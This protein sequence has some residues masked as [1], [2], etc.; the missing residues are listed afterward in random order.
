M[1]TLVS[2]RQDL[3]LIWT[4]TYL[5]H[6]SNNI[7][8]NDDT[9]RGVDFPLIALPMVT[10]RRSSLADSSFVRS[11][12]DDTDDGVDVVGVGGFA[13]FV[14]L[15]SFEGVDGDDGVDDV[16]GGGFEGC[17]NV[18]FSEGFVRAV[19]VRATS[20]FRDDEGAAAG[21]FDVATSSTFLTVTSSLATGL[22]MLVSVV[23]DDGGGDGVDAEC[24]WDTLVGDD[25]EVIVG[26][27]IM[28]R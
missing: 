22:T 5:S 26:T 12:S 21:C 18:V 28:S 3:V 16:D 8:I 20:G 2:V 17:A 11:I 14:A 27:A 24:C 4:I 10:P 6:E 7:L 15:L 23:T 13:F 9:S 25:D 1:S 19:G